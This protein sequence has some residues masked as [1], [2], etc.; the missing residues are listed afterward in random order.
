MKLTLV[1]IMILGLYALSP[2]PINSRPPDFK[3][4]PERSEAQVSEEQKL[5]RVQAEVG[6]VPADTEPNFVE[7]QSADPDAAENVAMA[8]SVGET[9]KEAEQAVAKSKESPAKKGFL[10]LLFLV[11]GA[12]LVI[13]FRAW[14]NRNVPV[15]TTNNT[16][17]W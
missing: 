1:A 9:M 5:M 6:H 15:P 4:T 14:A 10:G 7:S 13:G 8:N 3:A 16:M 17:K 12:T 11:L 2:A